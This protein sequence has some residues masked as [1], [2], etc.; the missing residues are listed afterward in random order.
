M[1]YF[2]LHPTSSNSG[3]VIVTSELMPKAAVEEAAKEMMAAASPA[4][5]IAPAPAA[6]VPRTDS[7]DQKTVPKREEGAEGE[8]AETK[9][10]ASAGQQVLQQ[11]QL[12]QMDQQVEQ[13]PPP[14]RKVV[15]AKY[16][17]QL[18][19][20]QVVM[21]DAGRWEDDIRFVGVDTERHIVHPLEIDISVELSLIPSGKFFVFRAHFLVSLFF[22]FSGMAQ[23]LVVTFSDIT[24]DLAPQ[25]LG[26]ALDIVGTLKVF[27]EKPEK[28]VG[29]EAAD[30]ANGQTLEISN[31]NI[32]VDFQQPKPIARAR[33]WFLHVVRPPH[34]D[35]EG[36]GEGDGGGD[37][38]GEVE[39]MD[40]IFKLVLSERQVILIRLDTVKL[41][42][43]QCVHAAT[44][45]LVLSVTSLQASM[46]DGKRLTFGGQVGGEYFNKAMRA[47]EPLIE[48]VH[49][50]PFA[51][52][53][54]V[55]LAEKGIV[56]VRLV[57]VESLELLI[58][59]SLVGVLLNLAEVFQAEM[60]AKDGKKKK[61]AVKSKLEEDC[62]LIRNH[63][64]ISL[65]LDLLKSGLE[66]V[67]PRSS[68]S[69]K[70]HHD[71]HHE[72]KE[73]S[74]RSEVIKSGGEMQFKAKNV[75]IVELVVKLQFSEVHVIG[76]TVACS[77]SSTR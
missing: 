43:R 35:E 3:K 21:S 71:H 6:A 45:V 65:V 49:G 60:A 56:K 26:T 46:V 28:N 48:T 24:V 2:Y 75:A 47:W 10:V 18:K 63:L 50:R 20:I 19:S 39:P 38:A 74:Y 42:I 64:G 7:L 37:G 66:G 61:G 31:T 70:G 77:V 25:L 33:A 76:R 57:T 34:W 30:Q 40:P 59:K 62:I 12:E 55:S 13:P 53:G 23:L 69:K 11:Q 58:S 51:F 27:S 22:L 52:E 36:D 1:F 4:G 17:C 15:V 9:S 16:G 67:V 72:K 54:A 29:E 41:Q 5:S 8:Q 73:K 68:S 14:Q 44:P 32:S